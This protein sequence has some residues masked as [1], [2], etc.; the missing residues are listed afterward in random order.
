MNLPLYQI[1]AFAER[2][3]Q[4][5]PAA[6]CPL[7]VWLPDEVLQAIAEANHLSETA[8]FVREGEAFRLRWFTPTQ[9]V[10]LCGHATLAAAHV[11]FASTGHEEAEI[12]F[13]TRSGPLRVL[14]EGAL[15]TLDFP[16]QPGI[17]CDS[18]EALVEGLGATP[19]ECYRATDYMAVFESE[20]AVAAL[21]PDFRQLQALD[22]RG[23]IATSPGNNDDFVSR[24]FA[25]RCGIDEDPVT[26][27]AHCTLAPYWAERLGKSRLTAQQ[28]SKRTG[29]LVCRVAGDRVFISG[30][31]QLYLEGHIDVGCGNASNIGQV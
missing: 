4:G 25:P 1:D 15:L 19:I 31:T 16:A 8:F 22:R 12:R 3:F 5:N 23:V 14:R 24:F 9:E 20:A 30:R 28:I 11:L 2:V 17:R 13:L 27:S 26:G 7:E 29:R 18:P 10:D 21:S 6:V